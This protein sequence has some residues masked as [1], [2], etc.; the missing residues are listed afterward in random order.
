[1]LSVPESILRLTKESKLRKIHCFFLKIW[2]RL[3]ITIV[4]SLINKDSTRVKGEVLFNM[5]NEITY[6]EDHQVM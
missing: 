5:G 2:A 6:K 4:I 1:M 3:F